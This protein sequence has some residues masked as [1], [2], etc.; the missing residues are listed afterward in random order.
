M[1]IKN[2][3]PFPAQCESLAIRFDF[4]G[5]Q[6]NNIVRKNEIHE[7]I[8]GTSVDFDNILNSATQNHWYSITELQSGL[9]L[10]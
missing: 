2:A 1:E 8:H 3:C 10:R 4:S 7:I 9:I 6:I 5:G